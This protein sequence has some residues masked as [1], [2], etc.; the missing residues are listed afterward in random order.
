MATVV[1]EREV[2]CFVGLERAERFGGGDVEHRRTAVCVVTV[3]DDETRLG[4]GHL[5]SLVLVG[6]LGAGTGGGRIGGV[7]A[8]AQCRQYDAKSQGGEPGAAVGRLCHDSR[9]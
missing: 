3:G 2:G 6:R 4:L 5:L 8:G 7:A 1:G 9:A